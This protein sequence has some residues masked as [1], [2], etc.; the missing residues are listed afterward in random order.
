[1]VLHLGVIQIVKQESGTLLD[2][3]CV[4]A[5][6]KWSSRLNGDG[7]VESGC[8][9]QVAAHEDELHEDL[10]QLQSVGVDDFI[11]LESFKFVEGGS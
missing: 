7:H 10:L 6:I 9:E 1:V 11:F 5:S 2:D 8:G 3:D 4:V